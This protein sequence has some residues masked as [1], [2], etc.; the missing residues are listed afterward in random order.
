MFQL[1]RVKLTAWYLLIILF[2][3]IF[4][5]IAFYNSS[6]REIQ[7]LMRRVEF[8]QTDSFPPPNLN[9][10]PRINIEDLKNA[11]KQIVINL[12]FIDI[13]ILMFAG[14]AGYFLAGKTLYPIKNMVDEQNRFITDSSHELRTP[15]TALKSEMEANLLE[16][17]ITDKESRQLIESN[18]EEVENLQI[19][20]NNLIELT[21]N[22]PINKNY[23]KVSLI[24]IINIAKKQVLP[25]AKKKKISIDVSITDCY[26]VGDKQTLSKLFIIFLDNSI[27]YSNENTSIII[28]SEIENHTVKIHVKD[29]GMGISHDDLSHIFDRF[30]R[31]DK[32]RSKNDVSGY[33]LGLSIAKKIVEEHNGLVTVNSSLNVGTTFTIQFPIKSN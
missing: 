2:I 26:I 28:T 20:V 6:N 27:K 11:E 32:S 10:R 14:A 15:L 25:L 12:I 21:Q 3:T 16:K 18:L 4:F 30:Y 31:A 23:A 17:N 7:R 9:S 1:A 5:S 8:E 22:Q 29:Q 19:L 33:G 24:E 13:G